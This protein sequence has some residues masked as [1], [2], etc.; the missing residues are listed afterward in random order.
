MKITWTIHP[1]AQSAGLVV[2]REEGD[3][4]IRKASDACPECGAKLYGQSPP[5][6]ACYRAGVQS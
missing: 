1:G 3:K 4:P 5:C 2:A 6:D